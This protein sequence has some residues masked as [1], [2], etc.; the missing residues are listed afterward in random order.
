VGLFYNDNTHGP[1][2]PHGA[3]KAAGQNE[4]PFGRD[5]HVVPSNTVIDSGP[6]PPQEG[7]TWGSEPHFAA[8]PP[9]TKLLWP[10]SFIIIIIK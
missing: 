6:G 5:T 3:A 1:R 9:I 4:M 10:L 2:N 8:M 7:K